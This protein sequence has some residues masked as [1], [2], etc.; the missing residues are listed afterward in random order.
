MKRL[1]KIFDV[2][3]ILFFGLV[4][5][6]N[7]Y[8]IYVEKLNILYIIPVCVLFFI[9]YLIIRLR[10]PYFGLFLFIF[11]LVTKFT[12]III[13]RTPPISD[14]EVML[15]AARLFAIGDYSFKE[16]QYF[17]FFPYQTIFA[18]Y[19]G[20]IIKIFG[21][22][23]FLLKFINCFF[24]AAT[25]YLV[26]RIGK[27][28]FN[29]FVGRV[30]GVLHAVYIPIFFMAPVLTNQ[31]IA[32]LFYYIALYCIVKCQNSYK[33][34]ILAGLFIAIGNSLRPIGIVFILAIFIMSIFSYYR[35]NKEINL[36]YFGV[37]LISYLIIFYSI[38]S[39]SIVTGVTDNGLKN[40]NPY[41]KFVTGLNEKTS[42][43]FSEEDANTL[44]LYDVPIDEEL[45]SKEKELIKERILISPTRM[46]SLMVKKV[47]YM[48]GDFELGVFTFPHL[49][50]K[51]I[52]KAGISFDYIY[53]QVQE[54]EKIFYTLIIGFV[55]YGLI[56]Y[57]RAD[58]TGYVYLLYYALTIYTG[59]HFLIEISFRYKYVVMPMVFILAGNGVFI[60]ADRIKSKKMI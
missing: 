36:K 40:N 8:F 11:S 16:F 26:Y 14:F 39:L 7:I 12:M 42:G 34:W 46:L 5:V 28:I 50:G 54:F 56:R 4:F 38:W 48:W 35:Q 19:Q 47:R 30:A 10:I 9:L 45:L 31:H 23:V 37:C 22:S 52:R 41:W 55:L 43:R 32:T 27:S 49:I 53:R 60:M 1:Q 2:Y 13:V 17:S 20:L 44:M 18:V 3:M 24:I 25:N 57:Y 33:K 6:I 21:D 15:R 29:E 58:K 51:D 59:V